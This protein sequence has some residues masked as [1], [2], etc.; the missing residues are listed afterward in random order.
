MSFGD[1]DVHRAGDAS[2]DLT[3]ACRGAGWHPPGGEPPFMHL[4][5]GEGLTSKG[6]LPLLMKAVHSSCTLSWV[7]TAR[8]VVPSGSSPFKEET[9][10]VLA[11]RVASFGLL[12]Q[13]TSF[14][15]TR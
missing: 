15:A 9:G 1:R 8:R 11:A 14:E 4:V 5:I 6:T 2:R 10:L 12:L 3:V 13:R 7:T